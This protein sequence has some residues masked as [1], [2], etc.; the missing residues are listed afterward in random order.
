MAPRRPQPRHHRSADAR[1]GRLRLRTRHARGA[2]SGKEA[3]TDG[4]RL[5]QP[6]RRAPRS[7]SASRRGWTTISP[8]PQSSRRC[9]QNSCSGWAARRN[10]IRS[11]A[12]ASS[13]SPGGP[14]GV[15]EVLAELES[16]V[17]ADIAALQ[18]ALESAN[19]TGPAARRAS[20]QGQRTDDR[21]RE[22]GRGWLHA[23]WMRPPASTSRS[24]VN[25]AHTLLDELQ[26]GSSSPP[27]PP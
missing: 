21:C 10:A 23:S 27:A 4:D 15:A 12:R 3:Q 2:G 24:C 9:A 13:S 22:L 20:H 19:S 14:Q 1:D 8:S 26:L 25:S 18:V 16:G 11:T 7:S 17:R 5:Y 6:T